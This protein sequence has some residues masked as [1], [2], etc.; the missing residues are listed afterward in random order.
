MTEDEMVVWHHRLNGHEFVQT[1]RDS[2]GQEAW[3]AA[4]PGVAKSQ[5]QL[6]DWTTKESRTQRE[7]GRSLMDKYLFYSDIL[8]SRILGSSSDSTDLGF[9][10]Q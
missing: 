3:H 1:L 9:S 5:R 6:S 8:K 2:E 4:V 7:V 10:R